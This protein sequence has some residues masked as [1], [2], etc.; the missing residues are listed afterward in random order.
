MTT[1]GEYGWGPARCRWRLI[2]GKETFYALA[3]GQV[4][5]DDAVAA[6]RLVV[7]G[8]PDTARLFFELLRLPDGHRTTSR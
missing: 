3:K 1:P 2:C 7:D 4:A 6:G 8:E 5:V